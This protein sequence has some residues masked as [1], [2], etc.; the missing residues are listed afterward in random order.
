MLP[1]STA[2]VVEDNTRILLIKKEKFLDL[3][4]NYPNFFKYFTKELAKRAH[5]TP[6]IKSSYQMERLLDVRI[7]YIKLKEPL[8]IKGDTD[9][10]RAAKKTAENDSTFCLVQKMDRLV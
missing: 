8:L 2:V 5:K 9:I 7:K 4:S 1:V 6:R 10:I 3:L